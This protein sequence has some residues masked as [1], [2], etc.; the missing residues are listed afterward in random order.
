MKKYILFLIIIILATATFFAGQIYQPPKKLK[1]YSNNH[2]TF[3]YEDG[4]GYL[5]KEL[6]AFSNNLYNDYSNFYDTKIKNIQVFILDDVDFVNGF[7][8]NMRNQ[9][10]LYINHPLDYLGLGNNPDQWMKF[11]FSHE[12]NHIF[13]GNT[14]TD[15]L[16]S[17]IPSGTIKK[18][19]NMINQPSLLHEGLSIYMESK[20]FDGRFKDDLFNTYLYAEI[21]SNKFPRYYYGGGA[22]ID[23]WT[24]AG[25]NYMYGALIV[26]KIEDYYGNKTLKDFISKLNSSIT[27]DISEAFF[28][29]TGENFDSFLERIRENFIDSKNK[30]LSKGYSDKYEKIDDSFHDSYN[31]KTDG[32][33]IYYYKE[34]EDHKFGI[35]KNDELIKENVSKFDVNNKG[36]L[37]Y[38]LSEYNNNEQSYNLYYTCE[39]PFSD[40]LIDSRVVEF[41]FINDK[42]IVYSKI[43]DGLTAIFTYD[44]EKN[45]KTRIINYDNITVSS[46]EGDGNNFYFTMNKN[47]QSDI[48]YYNFKDKSIHQIT[49]DEYKELDLFFS[50]NKL[51]YSANYQDHIY[52]IYSLDTKSYEIDKI[53]NKLPGAFNPIIFDNNL[54]Y[55]FYDSKGYH[56]TKENIREK[57][58]YKYTDK[59]S[60]ENKKYLFSNNIYS[61]KNYIEK[62]V[63]IPLLNVVLNNNEFYI[64]PDLLFIGEA[65][66]YTGEIGFYHN[67]VDDFVFSSYIEFDYYF[68]NKLFFYYQNNDFKYG[69]EFSSDNEFNLKDKNKINYGAQLSLTN[70]TFESLK[71]YSILGN[72]PQKNNYNTGYK[73]IFEFQFNIYP[74][75]KRF[76]IDYSK[77]IIFGKLKLTPGITYYKTNIYDVNTHLDLNYKLWKPH[78]AIEDGKYRFDGIDI[79]A[80]ISYDVVKKQTDYNINIDFQF[81]LF[82]WIPIDFPFKKTF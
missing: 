8:L 81:A 1:E 73:N 44:I 16:L 58:F 18:T 34:S 56:L 51:Y 27:T 5:V 64:G 30:F 11:V 82:Y 63:I 45:I 76:L 60:Y 80:G 42:K 55:F 75:E 19:L 59:K 74:E 48:Y 13:Y 77:D 36:V 25:F 53:T 9:I 29:T 69:Y 37:I 40:T 31:L 15:P 35:Y 43:K 70:T 14:V 4:L 65:L 62:P 10:R 33:N 46:F 21:L 2:F 17:W 54:Y 22:P 68:K 52:N 24:P 47:G 26:K 28:K 79:G 50:N 66:N 39:C 67:L 61:A 41:S 23:I 71:T 7:A 57:V 3:I 72:A 32:K 38:R 20:Y 12:L 78:Y 6:D 49:N